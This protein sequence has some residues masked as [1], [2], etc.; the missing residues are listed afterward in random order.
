[1]GQNFHKNNFMET[2]VKIKLWISPEAISSVS[3]NKTSWWPLVKYYTVSWT[4]QQVQYTTMVKGQNK[5]Y[6][7]ACTLRCFEW[8]RQCEVTKYIWCNAHDIS[9]AKTCFYGNI[10]NLIITEMWLIINQAGCFAKLWFLPV[11]SDSVLFLRSFKCY[12]HT[13]LSCQWLMLSYTNGIRH[14]IH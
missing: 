10:H 7:M 1:M 5:F 14:S 13:H 4:K 9:L 2:F 11:I 6:T 8:S 12:I 3:W